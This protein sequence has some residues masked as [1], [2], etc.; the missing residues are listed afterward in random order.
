MLDFDNTIAIVRTCVNANRADLIENAL[1]ERQ[2]V[3]ALRA[4][5]ESERAESERATRPA[6]AS[7]SLFGDGP[8]PQQ[9]DALAAAIKRRSEAETKR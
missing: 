1:F 4:Q 7:R 3:S 5:I 9:R 2:S 8:T 6:T